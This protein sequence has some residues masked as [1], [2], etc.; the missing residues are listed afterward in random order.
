[1]IVVFV[2]SSFMNDVGKRWRRS[3]K[4]TDRRRKRISRR[5]RQQTSA[6]STYISLVWLTLSS[7]EGEWSELRDHFLDGEEEGRD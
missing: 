3:A 4:K 1:V 2:V 6:F 5:D 7:G